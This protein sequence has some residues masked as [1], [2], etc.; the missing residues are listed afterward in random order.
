M[1]ALITI[2]TF[3]YLNKIININ[4]TIM[5]GLDVYINDQIN[6]KINTKNNKNTNTTLYNIKM[7]KTIL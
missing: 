5:I 7:D 4:L 3:L 6:S 2:L 1:M